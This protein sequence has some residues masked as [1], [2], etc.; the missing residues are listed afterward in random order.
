MQREVV[1]DFNGVLELWA[2]ANAKRR[3]GARGQWYETMSFRVGGLSW[4]GGD[5]GVASKT[6]HCGRRGDL[7]ASDKMEEHASAGQ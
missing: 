4:G 1:V 3:V 2:G 5:Y 6:V 7:P